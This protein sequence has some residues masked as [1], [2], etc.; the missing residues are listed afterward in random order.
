MSRLI[1]GMMLILSTY[2]MAIEIDGV[3]Y[4]SNKEVE[5]K[6]LVVDGDRLLVG[7][8]S[9]VVGDN[10]IEVEDFIREY[11]KIVVEKKGVT[12][13]NSYLIDEI[14]DYTSE[15]H[16]K[17]ERVVSLSPGITEKVFALGMGSSLIGRTMY[18]SYP[19]EVENIEVVG[20]MLEPNFEQILLKNTELVLMET[21]FKQGFISRLDSVGIDYR[22]YKSPRSLEDVYEDII[23]LGRDLGVEIRA[24]L[25]VASLRSKTSHY[26]RLVEKIE[27][28][29]SV[30]YAVSAGRGEYTAG[31]DTFINDIIKKGGGYNIATNKK[32]WSYTLEE[33]IVNNPDYIIAPI[34]VANIIKKDPKYGILKAV[35]E[36]RVIPVEKG[37]FELPGVRAIEVG[38]EKVYNILYR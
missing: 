16:I 33:L 28:K 24:R 13:Y 27:K 23:S 7:D 37:I 6:G 36:D 29:K 30:Y 22:L 20:S 5:E 21:H 35:R 11:K 1:L 26:D 10:S 38:V 31:G 12:Y 9:L 8:R 2:I 4:Y 25:I 34:D 17:R 15:E 14:K 32:G 3:R 19:K 18:S